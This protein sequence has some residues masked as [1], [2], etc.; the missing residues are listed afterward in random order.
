[1]AVP[2]HDER[3]F[4]FAQAFGLEIRRVVAAPGEAADEP[5]AAAYIAHA[6][7]E[8]LVNSG[9]YSGLPADEGGKAIVAWLAETGRAE[10]KVT[11]R[12]RDWL[13]S[14][15]R[16]WGTPIPV[17]YCPTD[18]VVPVPDDQLPVLL[19][20]TVEFAGSGDNPLNRDE[21]FLRRRRARAA[22]ARRGARPTP[23]TPSW[24]RRGTGSATCRR[25]SRT[26]RST[27]R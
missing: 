21:A 26:A 13:V 18:G 1:M 9:P 20:E 24:T 16:Y 3:D 12:L 22:A 7:G 23:W 27:A 10:P 6:A 4:E 8:V 5:M 11:Y 25:T 15:Q 17:I 19:P 14:R 2:A